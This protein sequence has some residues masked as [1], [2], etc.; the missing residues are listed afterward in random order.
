MKLK[1]AII[2]LLLLILT[3]HLSLALGEASSENA[4]H[5]HMDFLAKD[6][7]HY[8]INMDS[9]HNPIAGQLNQYKLDLVSFSKTKVSQ[10][11]APFMGIFAQ[12]KWSFNTSIQDE[13]QNFS[14]EAIFN[15]A[16]TRPDYHPSHRMPYDGD[17]PDTAKVINTA[18][19]IL[20]QLQI[21]YEYPFY[22]VVPFF[23]TRNNLRLYV[24]TVH[25]YF[26][27]IQSL[28]IENDASKFKRLGL[29]KDPDF[30]VVARFKIDGIPLN[31]SGTAATKQ[32]DSISGG[33]RGCYALMRITQ[34]GMISKMEINRYST[35]ANKQEEQR[36]L[37]T[38]ED[39]VK[40]LSEQ[41]M[42]KAEDLPTTL[43]VS[44]AKLCLSVGR[45]G[46]TYPIWRFFVVRD[47]KTLYNN[48]NWPLTDYDRF[49]QY[50][51][52]IDAI[53]GELR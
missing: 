42:L 20:D 38:F 8:I 31:I 52:C 50:S 34:S 28:G 47:L 7:A 26:E 40:I 27:L 6:G 17:H 35:I 25:E 45:K 29:E 44:G 18:K 46:V 41:D 49:I 3:S 23:Q 14:F 24:E 51:I 9:P 16:D 2:S 19:T 22:A 53:T 21:E 39:A 1:P 30:F 36:N 13:G 32:G 37:L 15:S 48:K 33:D 12:E 4:S 11:V 43:D 10:A 5:F